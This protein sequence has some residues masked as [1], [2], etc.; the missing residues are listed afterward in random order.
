VARKK[1]CLNKKISNHI[2]CLPKGMWETPQTY[3]RRWSGQMRLKLTFFGHQGKHYV[4]R[5]SNTSHHPEN[6]TPTMKHGGGSI[7]LG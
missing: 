4:W 2:W 5:K 6:T 3:G 1:L 7:K